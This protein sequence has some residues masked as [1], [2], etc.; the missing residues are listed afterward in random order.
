MSEN[1]QIRE[2]LAVLNFLTSLNGY[3]DWDRK[4]WRQFLKVKYFNREIIC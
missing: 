3:E 2:Q 1:N 4:K